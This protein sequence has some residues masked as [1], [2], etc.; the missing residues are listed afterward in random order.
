MSAAARDVSCIIAVFNGERYL[1]EALASV[2][3][4]SAGAPEVIV[5]DDG[6][7]DSTADIV[8]RFGDR[9]RCLRQ[10]NSGQAHARNAGVAQ[11]RGRFLA[12]LDADDLWCREKLARQLEAF[13]DDPRLDY[14]VTVVENFVDAADELVVTGRPATVPGFSA[15]SLLVRR[16]A[17]DRVGPF[18]IDLAHASDTEWFLRAAE[19]GLADKLI[20]EVLVRR[21]LHADSRSQQHNRRSRREYL[22]LVKAHLDRR[23]ARAAEK[24]TP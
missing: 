6:S 17:F 23:R 19:L 16:D 4:Q 13:A 2:I 1:S 20:P 15:V 12:F 10:P 9:V 5:V 8:R 24:G 3:E 7:T 14:C 18:R 21:R 22:G 11:A